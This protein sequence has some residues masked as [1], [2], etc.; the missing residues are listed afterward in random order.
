MK[1]LLLHHRAAERFSAS[2]A[3]AGFIPVP[4]FP[5]ERLNHIVAAHADTLIFSGI[6]APMVNEQYAAALPEEIVLWLTLTPDSP[7]G[8]YPT[9]TAFNALV[10]GQRLLCRPESLAPS[11]MTAASDAGMT[12]IPVRQGYAKCAVLAIPSRM[13]AITADPGMADGMEAC[14]IRV[15]RITPGHI[16]LDGCDYGFIG[17]ASFVHDPEICCSMMADVRPTVY[18]FGNISAHPDS[19]SIAE[20]LSRL[21]C[22][23][24]SFDGPLTD[25]GGAVIL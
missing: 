8:D 4:L 17:G 18:F 9:D 15:L 14:G 21:G 6:G 1:Y 23:T 5:D 11:V 20:F 24:V 12:I 13:A 25:F 3:S 16:A 2:L 10:M 7:Y 19:A 22:R